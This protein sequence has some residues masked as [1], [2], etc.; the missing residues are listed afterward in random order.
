MFTE[1]VEPLA[2][3]NGWGVG[4]AGVVFGDEVLGVCFAPDGFA[5]SGVE[6]LDEVIAFEVAEGVGAVF[7]DGEAGVSEV[8]FSGPEELG[9]GGGPV[10]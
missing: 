2:I 7:G 10:V 6:A 4:A 9:S 5:G 3:D 1:G 8:D